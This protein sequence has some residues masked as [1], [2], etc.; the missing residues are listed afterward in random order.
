[1]PPVFLNENIK[2][3]RQIFPLL[4]EELD[5]ADDNLPVEAAASGAPTLVINGIYIHSR[6]DPEREAARLVEAGDGNDEGPALVLGFGLGYAALAL[7]VKFPGRPIIIVEKRPEILKKALELRDFRAFLKREGL[8]FVLDIEG[9][10][11][12]LSLFKSSPGLPP[13]VIRNRA[14]MGL[15]GDWYSG[16]EDKIALWNTRATVNRLTQRRFG[17][18]WVRN[19]SKNLTALRDKPGISQLEGILAETD[20]PV[21]LAAAGPSLDQTAPILDGIFK[22]CLVVAVDTSLRFLLKHQI[23]PDFVLS[24]DPQYWNFRHLDRAPAPKTNLVAESAVYPALLRHPFGSIFLCASFFPMGRYIEGRLDPKGDLGTGGSVA[25]SAWDFSR[26][27]GARS[28]WISGLDLSYP[29][30]KTHFRG[31]AFEEKSLASSGRFSP[32]ETANFHQ[33]GDGQ[34][35][36]VKAYGGAAVLSDKRLSLYAFWFENRF[37]QYPGLSNYSLLSEGMEI[38]GLE[39]KTAADIL[40]LPERR[41]SIDSILKKLLKGIET[42]FYSEQAVKNRAEKFTNARKA[43]LKGLEEIE[44]LALETSGLAKTALTKAK[45]GHLRKKEQDEVLKKLKDANKTITD[46]EVKEIAGF[47]FPETENWEAEI[48][49]KTQGSLERHLE[50]SLRFY[51]ALAGAAGYTFRLLR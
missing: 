11:G 49:A 9:V 3:L 50:F 24:V 31:A 30:L 35:F 19:L 20:I 1:M 32:G 51:D 18:R 5:K 37:N 29:K 6:R 45:M 41:E 43:L 34:S 2:T 36:K 40:A 42:E 12:A 28:L 38:K 23:D 26:L 22:R 15:D 44:N 25:T 48:S 46:S 14:L 27:L 13:L 10:T 16:V 4:A 39:T 33:L 47:L 8:V 7:A 17:N 21:F